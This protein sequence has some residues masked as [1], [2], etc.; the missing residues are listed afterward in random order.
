VTADLERARA[1]ETAWRYGAGVRCLLALLLACG[2]SPAPSDAGGSQDAGPGSQDAGRSDAERQDAGAGVVFTWDPWPR[3]STPYRRTQSRCNHAGRLAGEC[4]AGFECSAAIDVAY[5]ALTREERVCEATSEVTEVDLRDEAVALSD[6]VPVRL[7]I[8]VPAAEGLL[9]LRDERGFEVYVDEARPAQTLMLAR[10]THDV[11]LVL[12]G[13]P[14]Q[15]RAGVLEVAGPGEA[16]LEVSAEH[17]DVTLDPRVLRVRATNLDTGT[18]AEVDLEGGAGVLS[19]VPGPQRLRLE[20]PFGALTTDVLE[21]GALTTDALGARIVTVEG[22]AEG[23]EVLFA[24]GAEVRGRAP[25]LGGAYAAPVFAGPLDVYLERDGERGF[26]GSLDASEDVRFDV[27]ASRLVLRGL[28]T[29]R[30]APAPSSEVRLGF[31][32][33]SDAL[34]VANPGVQIGGD[35]RFEAEV[36]AGTFG[37]TFVGTAPVVPRVAQDLGAHEL[38]GAP[39]ELDLALGGLDVELFGL[40]EGDRGEL[41]FTPAGG[42]ARV[43]IPVPRTGDARVYAQ[44]PPGR[45]EA[46]HELAIAGFPEGSAWIGAVDL[47]DEAR[48]ERRLRPTVLDVR[49]AYGSGRLQARS[50]EIL[51]GDVFEVPIGGDGIARLRVYDGVYE[52]RRVCLGAG[53][54]EKL[55]GWTRFADTR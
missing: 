28:L 52:L 49:T 5:V 29:V 17:L 12:E 46:R 36:F 20:A 30:G 25:I 48:L 3:G 21:S 54:G 33:L 43:A 11:S 45:W 6:G 42:G 15:V 39:L 18:V 50:P 35:A 34:G 14:E 27:G 44:L 9:R 38:E 37:L 24:A 4:P 51:G 26:V 31:L 40:P 47:T 16:H 23:D 13:P 10:G 1:D 32:R 2:S 55:L 41:V 53:C 19:V 8:D 22:A 7:T